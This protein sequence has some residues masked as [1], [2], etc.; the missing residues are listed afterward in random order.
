[1]L[2]CREFLVIIY[3]LK[4][5]GIIIGRSITFSFEFCSSKVNLS[6]L[7]EKTARIT[8]Q[9]VSVNSQPEP[10]GKE[11]SQKSRITSVE[12]NKLTSKN[13]K[14]TP[15]LSSLKTSRLSAKLF[16]FLLLFSL[17]SCTTFK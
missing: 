3:A 14:V 7:T 15:A 8:N 5:S 4:F 16:Y 12:G 9:V 17:I 11:S 6:C 2:G 13:C 1:M 10:S